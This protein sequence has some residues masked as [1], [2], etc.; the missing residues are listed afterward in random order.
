[1]YKKFTLAFLILS[2]LSLMLISCAQSLVE[3]QVQ[4]GIQAA[5]RNL[6]DEA[7]FRW[8][9]MISSNP[10]S[11]AAHNNLAIAYEKKGLWEDAEK[12]YETALKLSPSN[13][14]IKSNY[15]QF[16]KNYELIRKNEKD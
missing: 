3:N 8:K 13:K 6:W 15:E 7:I 1:M 2:F 16:K 9:K 10:N 4:F 11:A 5:Q 14:Y 12:E